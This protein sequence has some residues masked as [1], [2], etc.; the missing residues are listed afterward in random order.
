MA[1]R[2]RRGDAGR[3]A[4]PPA[5][6]FQDW[7]SWDTDYTWRLDARGERRL[8]HLRGPG[9]PL[10]RPRAVR[11]RPA[12]HGGHGGLRHADSRPQEAHAP[13]PR[14]RE[15]DRRALRGGED[16]AGGLLGDPLP[17]VQRRPGLLHHEPGR[18]SAASP[19][20]S[21]RSTAAACSYAWNHKQSNELWIG[22]RDTPN[23]TLIESPVLQNPET[24]A[25]AS[26]PTGH[27]LGYH[28]AMLNLM[29]DFYDVVKAGGKEPARALPRPTFR[30]G[31][32][33]N[34][35]PQGGRGVQQEAGMGEGG[36]RPRG[37]G[38]GARPR[39]GVLL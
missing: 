38:N 15:G 7:L 32:R 14:L 3:C 13:G 23:E 33:G 5:R 4:W 37:D 11:H 28:D 29:R 12:R 19:T 24:A 22:H 6:W 30:T 36:V 26:L 21:S 31:L 25:Y 39:L 10:V 8:E 18:R 34:A 2:V 9:Q 20:R 1:L 17:P 16:R 27:P 35:D